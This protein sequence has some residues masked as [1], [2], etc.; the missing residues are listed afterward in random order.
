MQ[1]FGSFQKIFEVS[2]NS[3]KSFFEKTPKL[4]HCCSETP[5]VC[6][7]KKYIDYGNE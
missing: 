7:I 3:R 2:R 4:P 6:D 1:N 5:Y